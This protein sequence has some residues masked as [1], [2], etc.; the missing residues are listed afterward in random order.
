VTN[1]SGTIRCQS[2][3]GSD[4]RSEEPAVPLQ[5]GSVL[6]RRSKHSGDHSTGPQ[7][8]GGVIWIDLSKPHYG[9]DGTPEPSNIGHV[10]SHGCV[11]L[12]NWDVQRVAQWARPGT[13]VIFRE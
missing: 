3:S 9:N 1:G 12:T 13:P 6:G 5:P 2:V 7:Q 11:R 8:S 10:Q 4:R